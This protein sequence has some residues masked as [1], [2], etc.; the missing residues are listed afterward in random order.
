MSF[1]TKYPLNIIETGGDNKES[2]FIKV[3]NEFLW[4]YG[5]LS[6][7]FSSVTGHKHTGGTNDAPKI[8]TAGIENEAITTALFATDAE[9]PKATVATTAATATNAITAATATSVEWS[10]VEGKPSFAAIPADYVVEQLLGVNGY[11]KW[12]SGKIEQ[13][14]IVNTSSLDVSFPTPFLTACINVQCTAIFNNNQ[15]GYDQLESLPTKTGFRTY[16]EHSLVSMF[17]YAVGY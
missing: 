14:G 2:G 8:G 10:G 4:L 9:C 17:Y 13:W 3:K 11:T 15:T 16:R 12:Q 6:S 5:I 1:E 7:L